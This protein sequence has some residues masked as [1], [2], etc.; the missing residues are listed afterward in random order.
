VWYDVGV[1]PTQFYISVAVVP[2][3]T[4]VAVML[5][6]LLNNN[7]MNARFSDLNARFGDIDKRFADMNASLNARFGDIDKRFADMNASLNARFG[8]IDKRFADM[9]VRF[10]DVNVRLGELGSGL[11]ARMDDLRGVLQTE[12][13]KNHSEMLAKFS[14]LDTRLIRLESRS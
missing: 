4:I 1:S 7:N 9:N 12:M 3:I 2:T 13:A 14:E 10:G 11:N 5:G 6:L 8:D